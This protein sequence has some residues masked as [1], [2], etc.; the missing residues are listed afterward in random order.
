MLTALLK[1]HELWPEC[2]KAV[3]ICASM[4]ENLLSGGGGVANNTGTEQHAHSRSLTSAFVIQFLKGIISK[5]ASSEISISYLVSVAEQAG[6]KLT[7]SE[8]PKTRRGTYFFIILTNY[9]TQNDINVI[10]SGRQKLG[11]SEDV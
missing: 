3:I 9:K 6:L 2:F 1:W 4:R 10:S 5:L 7:L 11:L 8:T